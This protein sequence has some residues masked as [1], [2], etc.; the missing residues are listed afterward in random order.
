VPNL[1]VVRPADANE[2]A[3]ALADAL[4]HD[5]PTALILSRQDV[6]VVTDGRAISTGAGIVREGGATPS[7]VLIGTGSEVGVCVEAAEQ[8]ES[9]GIAARVV[10]MPSWDRFAT[11][12]PA[13]IERVLGS[14][15]PR[16]SVEAGSTFGWARWADAHVGIDRFGASAPGSQVLERLGVSVDGVIAAARALAGS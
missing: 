7:V 11:Q 10:S 12:P 2:T 6:P 8:L 14:G 4:A 5:G 16:L 9:E 13:Q 3:V 15:I 1:H